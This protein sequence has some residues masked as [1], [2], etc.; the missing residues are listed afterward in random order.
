MVY[1]DGPWVNGLLVSHLWS[2]AAPSSRAD[3][4]LTQ[5]QVQLS[6]AFSS[7]WYIQSSPVLS[8][9][10]KA[11][12]GQGWIIP[13]GVDVGRTFKVGSQGA[14]LQVGAYYNVKKAAGAPEW[15]LQTQLTWLY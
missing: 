1:V 6:Y 2:F 4:S 13:I 10:W 8:Y 3:V 5:M 9:D 11:S 14:S 7:N 12:S 15:V